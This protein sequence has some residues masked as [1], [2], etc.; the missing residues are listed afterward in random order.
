[1]K[2][3]LAT[4]ALQEWYADALKETARDVPHDEDIMRAGRVVQDL[5]A[6]ATSAQ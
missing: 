1:V 6:V 3:L 4:R 2:Q 5:R